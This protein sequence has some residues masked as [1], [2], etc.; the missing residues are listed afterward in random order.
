MDV[1]CSTSCY[2]SALKITGNV[3]CVVYCQVRGSLTWTLVVSFGLITCLLHYTSCF[4]SPL[5]QM[6]LCIF[7]VVLVLEEES[8]YWIL[9]ELFLFS[10][11]ILTCSEGYIYDKLFWVCIWFSLAD[12]SSQNLDPS[13]ISNSVTYV[14]IKNHSIYG[15]QDAVCLRR[16][17]ETI[18]PPNFLPSFLFFIPSFIF[19]LWSGISREK[20][21]FWR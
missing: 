15:Y 13:L 21:V 19:S 11:T 1:L 14:D 12:M 10:N 9:L 3:C 4:T 6:V 7:R 16:F 5:M 17:S 8:L 18:C 20:G 2:I